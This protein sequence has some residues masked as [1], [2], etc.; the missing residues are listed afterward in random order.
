MAIQRND[1]DTL[2]LIHNKIMCLARQLCEDPDIEIQDLQCIGQ[3]AKEEFCKMALRDMH[4]MSPL[5]I[6]GWIRWGT[7]VAFDRYW[8]ERG[9]P[10]PEQIKKVLN[11]KKKANDYFNKIYNEVIGPSEIRNAFQVLLEQKSACLKR[12]YLHLN[13]NRRTLLAQ[14][15][16]ECR[17]QTSKDIAGQIFRTSGGIDKTLHD[18]Y[19]DLRGYAADEWKQVL[20]ELWKRPHGPEDIEERFDKLCR[21]LLAKICDEPQG[22]CVALRQLPVSRRVS[23]SAIETEARALCREYIPPEAP[24]ETRRSIE[25]VTLLTDGVS[26]LQTTN[27]CRALQTKSAYF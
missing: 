15:F 21:R 4:Q 14:A 3:D 2:Q 12:A 20:G 5:D 25:A 23:M 26:L 22:F 18:A 6:E 1:H 7:Y 9:K 17:R 11:K 8:K 13:L 19:L 27:I 24:L 16:P 10:V